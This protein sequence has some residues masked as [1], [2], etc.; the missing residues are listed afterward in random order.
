LSLCG[1]TLSF[2]CLMN[3]VMLGIIGLMLPLIHVPWWFVVTLALTMYSYVILLLSPF[4]W[5]N[6]LSKTFQEISKFKRSLV[7]LFM[8]FTLKSAHQFLTTQVSSGL[9][10]GALYV[11]YLL[12]S[13]KMC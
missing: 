11:V 13:G 9:L 7:I 5:T 3:M 12:F 10:I 4:L 6:G 8:Y 2:G 1:K